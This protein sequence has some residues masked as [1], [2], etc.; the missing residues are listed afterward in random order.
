MSTNMGTTNAKWSFLKC[1]WVKTFESTKLL[2]TDSN[3]A[4]CRLYILSI[5]MPVYV[6]FSHNDRLNITYFWK[7]VNWLF[8]NCNQ[9][10]KIKIDKKWTG[11]LD[12]TLYVLCIILMTI[13]SYASYMLKITSK[14]C[15]MSK[16]LKNS[17]LK[18]L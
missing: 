15:T 13:L 2:I 3:I 5:V 16:F 1:A 6:L 12:S 9:H 4:W 18:A 14:Y 17:K 11:A 7:L 10:K 8:S